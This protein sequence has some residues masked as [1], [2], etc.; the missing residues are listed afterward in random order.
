[1]PTANVN[2]LPVNEVVSDLA[3]QLNLTYET[4]CREHTVKFDN[5]IGAGFIKAVT[6]ETG[7]GIIEY[8]FKLKEDLE[9]HFIKDD[10]HPLKFMYCLQGEFKHRFGNEDTMH[11]LNQYQQATAASKNKY[12]HILRFN[13][14]VEVILFS[15]EIDRAN[16]PIWDDCSTVEMETEIKELFT[17]TKATQSFYHAGYYSLGLAEIFRSIKEFEDNYFLKTV[18]MMSVGYDLFGKQILQYQ[19]DL[20]NTDN[21][22]LLREYEVH[23]VKE[24]AEYIHKNIHNTNTLEHL[25]SVVGLTE[26]KLQEGFKVF[27]H[28]TVNGYINT[29]RLQKATE[30]LNTTNLNISE[31][32]YK[33]GLTSRSYFS[34]IFHENYHMTPSDY[35]K[36]VKNK[37]R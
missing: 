17:D 18:F 22:S 27:Y 34:K 25:T 5:T 15:L 7:M 13:K 28:N 11:V 6:L 2:S 19:D 12:G 33:I 4:N 10:T 20:K 8:N 37:D 16:F 26:S 36:S 31:I 29:I 1:M 35:R 32:V 14:D 3:E 24:A 23:K 30:L 21:R 9:I